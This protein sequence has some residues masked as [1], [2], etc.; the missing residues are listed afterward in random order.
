VSALNPT[1]LLEHLAG[2]S[3]GDALLTMSGLLCGRDGAGELGNRLL[4]ELAAEVETDSVDGLVS[5]LFGSRGF[6]GD[7]A[8]YHAEENSLLDR[9]LERRLGMPITL[10]AVVIEVG[11]RIGIPLRM[12]AMPGHVVVG[13]SD[14]DQF[15]DAFGGAVV[16]TD[17][18]R[19]RFASIF[20]A[21][22][23]LEP[24][25]LHDLDA[26]GATNRVGNNL[27]RTW[28]SDRSGKL[29]R[30]LELRAV[31]PGSDTDRKLVLGIAEARG[32]FDIAAALRE[33]IDPDDPRI[34]ELWARLN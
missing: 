22:A 26:I 1:Q 9:V 23:A 32:R 33:Q 8:N 3:L 12:V 18:L 6:Q 30:L 15:I 20:G 31:I 11:R 34:D 21:D 5:A 19:R 14:P 13:T 4:D 16:D 7:V 25:A 29:D 2:N 27:L 17:G 28:S 10:S 24:D